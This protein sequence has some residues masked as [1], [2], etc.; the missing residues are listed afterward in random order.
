MTLLLNPYFALFAVI[1]TVL[2]VWL[3]IDAGR[4]IGY[5]NAAT[6]GVLVWYGYAVSLGLGYFLPR[7]VH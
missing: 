1:M 6:N 2:V 7:L 3:F 4:Q 5:K